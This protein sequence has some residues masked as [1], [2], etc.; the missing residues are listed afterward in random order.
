MVDHHLAVDVPTERSIRGNTIEAIYHAQVTYK[1]S[2]MR[3]FIASQ[4]APAIAL[5]TA[6]ACGILMIML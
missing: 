6:F 2:A 3:G 5:I 4:L 1:S